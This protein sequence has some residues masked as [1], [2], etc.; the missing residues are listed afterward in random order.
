MI[1]RTSVPIDTVTL[2]RAD[3]IYA[4]SIDVAVVS[5]GETLVNVSTFFLTVAFPTDVAVALESANGVITRGV[6]NT[7]VDSKQA[8]INV[9]TES[10]GTVT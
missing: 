6:V 4:L 9:V 8:L 3:S 7:A 1:S 2:V 10:N 5:F